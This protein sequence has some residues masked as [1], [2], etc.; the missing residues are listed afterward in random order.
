M[1]SG[2]RF[3][4]DNYLFCGEHGGFNA[5]AMMTASENL[6]CDLYVNILHAKC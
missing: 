3:P 1:Y 2:D 5:G 6:I 4:W